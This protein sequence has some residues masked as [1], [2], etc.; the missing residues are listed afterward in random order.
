MSAY[1][2]T[3]HLDTLRAMLVGAILAVG[4]GC[5]Q[6]NDSAPKNADEGAST[7]EGSCSV[8]SMTQTLLSKGK[9]KTDLVL[10]C[11]DGKT[12]TVPLAKVDKVYKVG[13]ALSCIVTGDGPEVQWSCDDD[14]IAF[15]GALPEGAQAKPEEQPA[16]APTVNPAEACL[17]L[18]EKNR[19]CEELKLEEGSIACAKGQSWKC[20]SGC[21]VWLGACASQAQCKQYNRDGITCEPLHLAEGK[22]ACAWNQKWRCTNSCAVWLGKCDEPKAAPA[23]APSNSRCLDYNRD[24]LTCEEVESTEG[25]ACK[26]DQKWGCQDGCATWLG[27]CDSGHGWGPL[28]F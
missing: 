16:A 5:K 11:A 17:A 2:D 20:S 18:S 24:G 4:P 15:V 28:P 23:P 8:K 26:W 1:R 21:A 12:H 10:E 6:T 25:E 13:D 19:S 9:T 27:G 14:R 22:E 7:V 3:R